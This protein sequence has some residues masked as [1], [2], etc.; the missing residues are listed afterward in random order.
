MSIRARYDII[1]VSTPQNWTLAFFSLYWLQRQNL[2]SQ[3]YALMALFSPIILVGL[4]DHLHI[5]NR[6]KKHNQFVNI[7]LIMQKIGII[8]KYHTIILWMGKPS[9]QVFFSASNFYLWYLC[10]PVAKINVEYIIWKIYF[11]SVLRLK[12]M[13]FEWTLRY[14]I[15]A[16]SNPISIVLM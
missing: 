4:W 8:N 16:Q 7:H 6:R 2:N 14:L 11:I 10:S 15:L 9:W 5:P 3:F 13:A 12:P 1:D